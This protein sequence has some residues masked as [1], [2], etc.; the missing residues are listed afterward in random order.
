MTMGVCCY[1]LIA[2]LLTDGFPGVSRAPAC[3][4][5]CYLTATVQFEMYRNRLW[6]LEHRGSQPVL[7]A[8]THLHVHMT[9]F[10]R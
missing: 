8:C 5:R 4:Y 1:S 2:M 9:F 10:K 7:Y 3:R 6:K